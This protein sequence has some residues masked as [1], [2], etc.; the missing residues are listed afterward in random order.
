MGTSAAATK[1][2]DL[3]EAVGPKARQVRDA[4]GPRARELG[5]AV[6]PR[7]KDIGQAVKPRVR[8]A[9][10]KV[11][12]WIAGEEPHKSRKWLAVAAAG[13]GAFLAFFLD[14]VSGKRRRAVTKDWVAARARGVGQRTVRI[15]RSVGTRA[16]GLQERM[17]HR[18]EANRPQNDP[19][20]AQKVESELFQAI[21]VP[22][23]QISTNAENGVVSLRGVV[24]RPSQIV[25]IERRAWDVHGVRSVRNLLH[26]AGT[27]APTP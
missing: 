8:N 4:I 7:I 11:G 12:F 16:T 26:L 19:T 5:D 1:V 15:G 23:G 2:R 25:D 14:P 22:S 6:G 20:L 17:A 27:P 10:R 24:E 21:D 3:G 9:R 18:E 13:I